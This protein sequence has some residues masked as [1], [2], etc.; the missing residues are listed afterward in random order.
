MTDLALRYR[1]LAV[2]A[3]PRG[4]GALAALTVALAWLGLGML[5]RATWGDFGQLLIWPSLSAVPIVL[6]FGWLLA[7]W[8][9]RATSFLPWLTMALLTVLLNALVLGLAL[10]VSS[11]FAEGATGGILILIPYALLMAAY[12]LLIFGLPA[13]VIALPSAYVWQRLLRAGFAETT[14]DG[15]R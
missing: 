14:R 4:A 12:G 1:H 15:G 8:A 3:G 9:L 6:L 2:H 7:P 13:L 11:V 5:I 10:A